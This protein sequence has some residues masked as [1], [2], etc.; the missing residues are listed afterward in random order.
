[1]AE[2][3]EHL[4]LTRLDLGCNRLERNGVVAI[5]AAW[6][7]GTQRYVEELSFSDY[8][9]GPGA[10]KAVTDLLASGVSLGHLDLSENFLGEEG[11]E[12]LAEAGQLVS[13]IMSL[14]CSSN[15]LRV[16]GAKAL[17]TLL[18][19]DT[20]Q[21][22]SL[23]LCEN[24]I[25][26][27]GVKAL[28]DALAGNTSLTFLG[29]GS[30]LIGDEGA[31]SLAEALKKNSGLRFLDLSSSGLTSHR[32]S[33]A[34]AKALSTALWVNSSLQQLDLSRNDISNNGA[35]ALAAS[36]A[37][38]QVFTSLVLQ[39]TNVDDIHLQAIHEQLASKE[40]AVGT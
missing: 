23:E 36:L 16:A 35:D 8:L 34:G 6:S 33:D 7:R 38:N 12:Y 9:L 13:R 2:A 10:G 11:S 25:H 17:A 32:I 37:E 28:A 3:L 39:G 24:K 14:D 22:E 21:L 19:S 30:N 40:T 20:L 18:R 5:T 4:P 27:F 29:L 1:L 15:D 26:D 31:A